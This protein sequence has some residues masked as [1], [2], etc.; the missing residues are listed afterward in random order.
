MTPTTTGALIGALLALAALLFGF[1]GFILMAL[2]AGVGAIVGRIVS[3]KLD[4]RGLAD[5][6]TGRR[7]S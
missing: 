7:T 6:I 3:G 1:W 4:V 2:F 5:V